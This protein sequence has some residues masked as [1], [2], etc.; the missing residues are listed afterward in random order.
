M[1]MIKALDWKISC[2]EEEKDIALLLISVLH[3]LPIERR[4]KIAE[5]VFFEILPIKAFGQNIY[6]KPRSGEDQ[7]SVLIILKTE[8]R[9]DREEGE[10]RAIKTIAHE[11]GHYLLC[12]Y[13]VEGPNEVNSDLEDQANDMK[14]EILALYKTEIKRLLIKEGATTLRELFSKVYPREISKGL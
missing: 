8:I 2:R 12:H 6:V 11:L 9:E 1:K 7:R 5:D 4:Q 14:D 13:K 10:E 3:T